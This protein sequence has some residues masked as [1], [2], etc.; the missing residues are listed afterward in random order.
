MSMHPVESAVYLSV[1]VIRLVMPSHLLHIVFHITWYA[2]D[3]AATHCGFERISISGG[4]YPRLVDFF[5]LLH[6]KFFES[7]YGNAEVPMDKLA[8]T[9]H[10]GTRVATKE[11]RACMTMSRENRA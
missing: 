7:N 6:H 10:D 1:V 8:G 9:F 3:P 4:K 11:M 5:H 2:V